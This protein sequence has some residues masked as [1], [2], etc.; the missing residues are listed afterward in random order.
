MD[1]FAGYSPSATFPTILHSLLP[2]CHLYSS[3][4]LGLTNG[5][6]QPKMG[7]CFPYCLPVSLQCLKTAMSLH[8]AGFCQVA[9]PPWSQPSLHPTI[10]Y[11]CP[12][13]LGMAMASLC[14]WSWIRD[15]P[16][17]VPVTLPAGA[18]IVPSLN[19]LPSNP[20]RSI[21]FRAKIPMQPLCKVNIEVLASW[22]RTV[23]K[24][25]RPTS[26]KNMH[27]HSQP[28]PSFLFWQTTYLM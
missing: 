23:S 5:G 11:S 9:L 1:H 27:E 24:H 3:F 14:C 28:P 17:F 15:H 4:L 2:L 7:C 21:L 18:A 16:L 10:C 22:P 12:F 13:G 8:S 19:S 25:K 26:I 6:P 20:V